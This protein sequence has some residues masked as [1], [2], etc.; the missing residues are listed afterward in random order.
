MDFDD[1]GDGRGDVWL[2]A[3]FPADDPGVSVPL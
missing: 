3:R 2:R 1:R